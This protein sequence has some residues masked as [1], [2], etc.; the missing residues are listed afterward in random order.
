[1]DRTLVAATVV[2]L[3]GSALSPVAAAAPVVCRSPDGTLAIEVTVSK[4]GT[5]DAVPQYRVRGGAADVIG[6]SRLGV[7]LADGGSLG[8]PCEVTGVETRSILDRYTQFPG[9][10]REVVGHASE[11]TVRLR[12]TTKPN[13]RWEV[14][15]RAYDDGVAFRYRFPA[16]EGWTELAIAGERT[17]FALPAGT[18][19]YALPLNGFTTSYEKRYQ[20]RPAAELPADW[21]L[22]LPLLLERPGGG[23][24]AITEA[25]VDEYAGLYL[26]PTAAPATLSARLSPRPKEPNLAVRAPLP[27]A[28][29]WRVVMAADRAG[30]LIESDLVLNLSKPCA[31]TDTSWIKPGKTTFPWWNGFVLD[32][33]TFQPGL[34][35][36]TAKHYLDFCAANGIEYHSLDGL[37]NV[38]WYGGTIVPYRGADP[39][40]ALPDIDLPG[41]LAY[42]KSKGVR[43]RLW[44]HWGAA[45]KHMARAFPLYKAWGIEGVMLDFMDRDDQEMNRFVRAAVKLAAENQLT[46]TL[47]GCP[48]P[49]GLERTYPNLLTSEGV[50]NLEYNKWDPL[51]CPPEHQVTVAFTRMLAGP[52]DFHQGSFRAVAP[53]AFKPRQ[54]SPLVM[55]T[56]CR[57]LASYVVYQNHLSMVADSPSAYAGHPALPALVKIPAT[58]DDTR[59]AAE[60]VGEWVAIAR[61]QGDVWHLGAMTDRKARTLTLPLQF[62]GPGRYA[63]ELWV[64]DAQAKHGLSR[65]EATV[66][67]TDEL[68]V[69]VAAAGGA[70][71][72]FTRAK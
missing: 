53:A 31:L 2:V 60:A 66:S 21:L 57:T 71:L 50:L 10:R 35:T 48:K 17:R 37:D 45:E 44:M 36:A 27:H 55:G 4:D 64:D 3:C 28:S 23:W 5:T 43:L 11:A 40:K 18:R 32:G 49:T 20:L 65:R 9:K 52:L 14:V 67:A 41:V 38:A 1:M 34:N 29:P 61:R 46:V 25:D 15:L 8:G 19:T 62:L 39:T 33:V 63:A 56:P 54:K 51:G 47:H 42:A 30:R 72:K 24:A 70:Y 59:V 6:W 16:Q 26:A 13:R 68:T 58:W 69:N 12:E 22:G 7:D